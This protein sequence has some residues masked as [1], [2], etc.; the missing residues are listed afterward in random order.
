M[1]RAETWVALGDQRDFLVVNRFAIRTPWLHGVAT[2]YASYGIVLFGVVLIAGYVVARRRDDL[3]A[4]ARA[5]L[6]GVGVLLAV[7]VNQP[8]VHAVGEQRPFDQLSG[9][10]VLVHRSAD[11]SF[12]SDHAVMAGATAVGLLFFSR[13]LGIVAVVAA[14]LMA[15]ARVYVGVH[16]PLDVLAGLV[17]GA[18]VAVL[19]QLAAQL[20]AAAMTPLTR[21]RWR[22]LVTTAP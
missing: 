16:F 9:V 14:V 19:V 22:P 18:T 15:V 1:P 2:A 11:A 7:A 21:G 8:I 4:T 20:L 13:R 6:A 3:V 10:L 17:V 5:L 12:P